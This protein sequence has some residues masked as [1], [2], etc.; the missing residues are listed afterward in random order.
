MPGATSEFVHGLMW[1]GLI[2]ALFAG[3]YIGF[4][5]GLDVDGAHFSAF[6]RWLH[7]ISGIA[8]GGW[9][10]CSQGSFSIPSELS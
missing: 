9:R 2:L 3:G 6:C 8:V 5:V 7:R 1:M 4:R 10:V